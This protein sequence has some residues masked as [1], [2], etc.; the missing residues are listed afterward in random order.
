MIK[1][2]SKKLRLNRETLQHLDLRAVVG[3]DGDEVTKTMT[4]DTKC[5]TCSDQPG[6]AAGCLIEAV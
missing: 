2:S 1:K 5:K 3:G 6:T 4:V